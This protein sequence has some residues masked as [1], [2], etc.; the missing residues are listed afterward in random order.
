MGIP[1][2][3]ARLDVKGQSVIKGVQ[4]EGLRVIGCPAEYALRYYEQS[5]DELIVHDAVATLY[6]RPPNYELLAAVCEG[7]FI[8][9]CIGGG[10]NSIE[11]A[12]RLFAVGADKV[13]INTGAVQN[14]SLVYEIAKRYGSQ[15]VSLN[16]EAKSCGNQSWEVYTN[17][18]RDRSGISVHA[19]IKRAAELGCGEIVVTSIDAEGT[20]SGC[21]L[22]LLGLVLESTKLPVIFGGGVGKPGDVLDCMRRN[23][24]VS[25]SIARYLHDSVGEIR[26]LKQFLSGNQIPVRRAKCLG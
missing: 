3:V 12:H 20:L 14:P 18:G 19:W 10:I 17:Y 4:F 25:V 1:R 2:I 8:P 15:A 22:E 5:A 16:I 7:V 21:D 6:G 13:C 23:Q 24:R 11:V 26:E 9:V